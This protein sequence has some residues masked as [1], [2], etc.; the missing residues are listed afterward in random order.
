MSKK[1]IPL[2]YSNYKCWND[3]MKKEG[4]NI[5]EI[6][7]CDIP[8]DVFR[9]YFIRH[10]SYSNIVRLSSVSKAMYKYFN[11]NDIWRTIF[12]KSKIL[13][14]YE[15]RL[16]I[17]SNTIDKKNPTH[18]WN[19]RDIKINQCKL[20]IKNETENIPF[21][22]FWIKKNG[23]NCYPS[24][25]GI[26]YP[27]H[28]FSATTIPNHKWVCIP[29]ERWLSYGNNYSELGITFS[30]N[31][32]QLENFQFVDKNK[33][34]KENIAFIKSISEPT[35]LKYIDETMEECLC[36]K[37]SFI[38]MRYSFNYI[39]KELNKITNDTLQNK[40]SIKIFKDKIKEF[41]NK[42][43]QNEIRLNDLIYLRKIILTNN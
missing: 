13:S 11:N 17:L 34:K 28:F 39:S 23:E 15:R 25:Q 8:I 35:Q 9:F 42:N 21:S 30:V 41:K 20:V 38:K 37:N 29:T 1:I 32:L 7:I 14:Y 19:K 4:I 22:I 18:Y 26:V 43:K 3:S 24:Y 33:R 12:I 6:N 27:G 5:K 2:G 10:L 40:E 31:V 36:F 16:L